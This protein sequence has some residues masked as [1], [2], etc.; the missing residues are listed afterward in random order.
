ML[1]TLVTPEDILNGV[2]Q[3]R[4]ISAAEAVQLLEQAELPDL[5]AAATAARDR[6]NDPR[7]ASYVIDRNV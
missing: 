6:H 3:G 5:A 2:L 4:R 1:R 7:R